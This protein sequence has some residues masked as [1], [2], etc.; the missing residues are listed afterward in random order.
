MR[1]MLAALGLVGVAVAM[2]CGSGTGT[3]APSDVDGSAS[4]SSGSSSAGT[5]SSG[6]GSS[7]SGAGSSSSSGASSS[8]SSSS[9]SGAGSSSSSGASSSSSSGSGVCPAGETAC[10]AMC[11]TSGSVCLTDQAGNESCA[12]SCAKSSDCASPNG[13]CAL[14]MSGG[15]GACVAYQTGYS[16]LCAVN[17]D[18]STAIGGPACAPYVKNDVVSAKDFVCKPN[19]AQPWDGCDTG[20]G[21]CPNG[22][23]CWADSAGRSYCARSCSND[24]ECGNVGVACCTGSGAPAATCNNCVFT[25]GGNGGC[26]A[27]P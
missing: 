9:S 10:G 11:C 2:A 7:S 27:C 15:A 26:T 19:D 1:R 23:D 12:K 8:S 18:C 3:G 6:Y 13:C 20:A 5:S 25:C 4:T 14:L 22:Y 16:C 24:S 17:R 21:C